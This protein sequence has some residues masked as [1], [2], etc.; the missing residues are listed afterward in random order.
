MKEAQG[1]AEVS[2][3]KSALYTSCIRMTMSGLYWFLIR[4]VQP[5]CSSISNKDIFW[6]KLSI[7]S[8]IP[9]ATFSFVYSDFFFLLEATLGLIL[10]I[11]VYDVHAFRAFNLFI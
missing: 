10:T 5:L 1:K 6:G 2:F 4:A 8:L 9:V 3:S 7:Y 11:L